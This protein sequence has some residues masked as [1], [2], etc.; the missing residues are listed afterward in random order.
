MKRSERDHFERLTF[1][2]SAI[3]IAMAAIFGFAPN[4]IAIMTGRAENPALIIHMHAAVMSAWLALLVVQSFLIQRGS[5]LLHRRL[6]MSAAV[7]AP[8]IVGL[9]I[10]I[11][12]EY[13]PGGSI[14]P[15]VVAV[16]L[17]RI[18]LFSVFV[19]LALWFRKSDL[20]S[21][22]RLMVLA[23]IA[24][25]D[26]AFFRMGWI[27]PDFGIESP[28]VAAHVQQLVLIFPMLVLDLK[29]YGRPHGATLFGI[30]LL[31]VFTVAIAMLW[32]K[33]G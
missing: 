20:Q 31:L 16:Q 29:R 28:V 23:S 12:I 27:L 18:V 30:A 13:F 9:M 2:V 33:A 5:V 24:V 26:A 11:A 14:G 15:A 19:A 25:I 17:R 7:L 6:G 21:H 32:P 22:K 10:V 3:L 8:V 1:P 4:S